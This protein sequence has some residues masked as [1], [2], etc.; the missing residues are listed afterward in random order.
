MGVPWN[1]KAWSVGA[2]RQNQKA[3]LLGRIAAS[4]ILAFGEKRFHAD[5]AEIMVPKMMKFHVCVEHKPETV[6]PYARAF[7]QK[8]ASPGFHRRRFSLSQLGDIL[9]HLVDCSG[10][11]SAV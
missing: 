5:G 3:R 1:V 4:V 7:H 10:D 2:F 9:C 8:A 11:I 6:I